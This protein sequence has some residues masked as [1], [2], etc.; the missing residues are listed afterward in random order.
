MIDDGYF[1]N[2]KTSADYVTY[3]DGRKVLKTEVE[4]YKQRVIDDKKAILADIIYGGQ[5]QAI[6]KYKSTG[7]AV[8]TANDTWNTRTITAGNGITITN[9]NGISGD[10]SIAINPTTIHDAVGVVRYWAG[11][12]SWVSNGTDIALT[13]NLNLPAGSVNHFIIRVIETTSKT[14]IETE[15]SATANTANIAYIKMTGTGLS[16]TAGFYTAIIHA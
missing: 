13:H 3:A 1:H 9:G 5:S 7:F 16:A 2:I 6:I 10:P 14:E 11:T 4:K 8:R 15:A 12:F